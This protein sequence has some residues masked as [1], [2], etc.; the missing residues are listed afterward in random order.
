MRGGVSEGR[1]WVQAGLRSATCWLPRLLSL[2]VLICEMG[3][4]V[5]P[6]RSERSGHSNGRGMGPGV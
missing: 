2:S 3:A 4:R 6:V 5:A 1:L